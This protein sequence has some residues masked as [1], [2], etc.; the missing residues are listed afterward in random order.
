M[1]SQRYWFRIWNPAIY[2]LSTKVQESPLQTTHYKRSVVKN[3]TVEVFI[4]Q[5]FEGGSL[6]VTEVFIW[7]EHW[8]DFL[9]A[10]A[11]LIL[12]GKNSFKYA[13]IDMK[14]TKPDQTTH[15]FTTN[16]Q[17]DNIQKLRE[18]S[19]PKAIGPL[20]FSFSHSPGSLIPLPVYDYRSSQPLIFFTWLMSIYHSMIASSQKPSPIPCN[21]IVAKQRSSPFWHHTRINYVACDI[22]I[23]ITPP[24]LL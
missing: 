18:T 1:L 22:N 11:I 21:P 13:I 17:T 4:P 23:N 3:Q 9:C 6:P 14:H 10:T 7:N 20:S 2:I 24:A 19:R 16:Q 15:I 8:L 5:E 12:W